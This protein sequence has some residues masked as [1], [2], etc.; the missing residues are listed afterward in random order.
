MLI[1]KVQL[2][3]VYTCIYANSPQH[4]YNL[5][6][7]HVDWQT[8]FYRFFWFPLLTFSYLCKAIHTGP[9]LNKLNQLHPYEKHKGDYREESQT[10]CG[11]QKGRSFGQS[12]QE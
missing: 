6:H 9:K 7:I 10:R 4:E 1:Q 2:G 5:H 3:I 11:E 8:V 12:Y